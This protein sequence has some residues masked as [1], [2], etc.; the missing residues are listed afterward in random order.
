VKVEADINSGGVVIA[1]RVAAS[2]GFEALDNAALDSVQQ[3]R[4]VP[5]MKNGRPVPSKIVI[6]ISF[7]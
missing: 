5:A 4:F 1:C 7:P 3:A 6:P 2:S